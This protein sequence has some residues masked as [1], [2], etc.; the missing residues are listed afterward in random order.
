MQ[1]YR[2]GRAGTAT[3]SFLNADYADFTDIYFSF[4]KKINRSICNVIEFSN[5]V[6]GRGFK[7][8]AE[9]IFYIDDD[10]F[11]TSLRD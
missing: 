10:C 3:R 9:L 6:N 2:T 1:S 8:V 5:A 4:N 11:K 7:K